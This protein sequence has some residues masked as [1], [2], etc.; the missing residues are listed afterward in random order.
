M[1]IYSPLRYRR[2]ANRQTEKTTQF[3]GFRLRQEWFA[4]PI[5]NVY[6]VIPIGEIY[7]VDTGINLTNY[8]GKEILVLDV[9]RQIFAEALSS[10]AKIEE[11]K[12]LAIVISNSGDLLGLP[13]DSP[14]SIFRIPESAFAALP[15]VY[16]EQ[17]NIQS[18]SSTIAQVGDR[19]LLLL[20][21]ELLFHQVQPNCQPTVAYQSLN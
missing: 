16:S 18:I 19:S 14:P 4:L 9:A 5:N 12:C 10:P 7:T 15:E 13:A 17:G 11:A 6:K 21:P 1:A 2:L 3:I 8:E 20:D